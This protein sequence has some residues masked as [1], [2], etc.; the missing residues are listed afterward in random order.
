MYIYNKQAQLDA[1]QYSIFADCFKKCVSE[2]SCFLEALDNHC[3]FVLSF[4][5]IEVI[6]FNFQHSVNRKRDSILLTRIYL[7]EE[8]FVMHKS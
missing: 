1:N 6:S 8:N 3:R 5:S 2:S 7:I 4:H